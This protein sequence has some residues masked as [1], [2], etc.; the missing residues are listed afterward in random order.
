M[1]LFFKRLIQKLSDN[2]KHVLFPASHW[3]LMTLRQFEME[4]LFLYQIP[5]QS[6][7]SHAQWFAIEVAYLCWTP[8]TNIFSPE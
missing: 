1:G 8:G 6:C 2:Y 4:A 5:P 3:F 7:I